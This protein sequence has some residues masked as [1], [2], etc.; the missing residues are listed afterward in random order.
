[1]ADDSARGGRRAS[2]RLRI[3]SQSAPE[4]DSPSG[5]PRLDQH[6]RTRT[7][8]CHGRR[9]ASTPNSV[10]SVGG[11]ALCLPHESPALSDTQIAHASLP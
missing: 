5:S 1:M 10:R 4:L 9:I 6:R 11:K 2:P 7:D 8:P 3:E